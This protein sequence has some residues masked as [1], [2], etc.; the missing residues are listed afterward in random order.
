MTFVKVNN[1]DFVRDTNSMGLSSTNTAE[2][3]E[4]YTKLRM[5]QNQKEGINRVNEEI[6]SLKNDVSEIKTLLSQLL[7]KHG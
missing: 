7:N 3:N 1:A 2:K 5:I 4:Y 6:N